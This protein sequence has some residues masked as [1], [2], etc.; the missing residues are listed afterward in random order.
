VSAEKPVLFEDATGEVAALIATLYETGQRLEELTRR[1]VDTVADHEGNTFVLQHAQQQLRHNEAAKKAAVLNALP[2]HIALLDANGLIVSVNQAWRQFAEANALHSPGHALGTNYLTVCDKAEG[3]DSAIAHQVA[4][5]V[6]SVLAQEARS[7]SIEYPCHSPTEQRWFLM[8]ATPMAGYR[9]SGAVVMHLN[10]T[11][12]RRS[13]DA[14]RA[15][16]QMQRELAAQLEVEHRRLM[17]AQRI[18]RIGSWEAD[19]ATSEVL[20]SDETHRIF[21]TDPATF[22]VTHERF[23]NLVHPEDRADVRDAFDKSLSRQTV[24]TIQHRLLLSNARIKYVEERW[25]CVFDAQG[26]ANRV[27]GTCQDITERTWAGEL[28]RESSAHGPWKQKKRVFIELGIL[29][30]GTALVYWLGARFDLSETIAHWLLQDQTQWDEAIVAALF[31]SLAL[32]VFA[33]SRLLESRASLR[34]L[35]RVKGALRLLHDDLDRQVEQRT[36]DLRS[37]NLSLSAEIAER[38][39]AETWLRESERRLSSMMSNV[40]LL[41]LMLDDQGRITYCNEYLLTLCGWS[42]QDVLGKSW[43]EWFLPPVIQPKMHEMFLDLLA[44]KPAAWHHEHEILTRAGLRRTI[45]WNNTLLRSAGG[46]VIGTASIG[47]DITQRVEQRRKIARLDR[48]RAVIGGISSAMLRLRDRDKLLEEACRVAATEGVFPMAWISVLD[49]QTR[50]F[51]IKTWHGADARSGDL[52]KKLNEFD[53]WPIRDRPS[54]RAF[55]AARPVVVNDLLIDPKMAPIREELLRGGY[56]SIAAFPLFVETSVVAV[57]MLLGS[58]RDFFD[59]EEIALLQWLT[60]DL[61]FAL[62]HIQKSQQLNYLAYYDPVT[63]LPNRQLFRDCLD[64]FINT[65]QQHHGKVCVEVVDLER[66]TQ[67]NNSLGRAIGDELLRQVGARFAEFLVEPYALGHIGA[68]TFAV[69][70]PQ[71]DEIAAAKLRDR[72]QEALNDPFMIENH[73]ISVSMQAGVALFPADGIDGATVFK[74]ADL[75]LKRAKSSGERYL[76]HSSEMN[77]R[78]VEQLALE[79]QLRTAI[80]T[81]QFI[82]HYQPKVDMIS[83]EMIGAEALIRW[84]HP[85][86]GLLNP[87]EFVTLAEETGL[88]VPIGSW[89]I[90]TVCAQQAT[91][92]KA[93]ISTVPIAVNLSSVQFQKGDLL[94]TIRDALAANAINGNLLDLELTE[95]VV[96]NDSASAAAILHALRKLGVGLALDDFGTGYSSLAHLKRFPFDSVKIDISF[97]ADIIRNSEDAAIATAIIAMAHSLQLKVVAEGVETLGQF[98]YLRTQGCDQMQGYFFSP[99]VT[100]EGFESDLRSGKRLKLPELPPAEQRTLLLVDDE[101]GVRAS[102]NRLLRREG[103]RILMAASGAEALEMLAINKVQVI[104]S[105][106]RMPGMS[107]TEFLDTVK[108]MYPSTIRMILS[109]YTDLQ[110]VTDSVNRGAVF[111]FLTKPWDDNLL[112]EL[113]RDAFRRYQSIDLLDLVVTPAS[114]EP[115]GIGGSDA[116]TL[117]H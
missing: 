20:W 14:L 93:G 110:V 106:Q 78:A 26:K 12:R 2:A 79:K 103:Y 59:A 95:S 114:D 54:Y 8:S 39:L 15:G 42:Q 48:I 81:R 24:C 108:Q 57:L 37:A 62:E 99:P 90:Q 18:A 40:E 29:A 52:I 21:E 51:D 111:K 49:P 117:R 65:A 63:G 87:A 71:S 76:Y 98:C 66:F 16:E 82:L 91:W 6:R 43:S 23:L 61:S 85:D 36:E 30:I 113:I 56:Q 97:V 22:A 55:L 1:E 67:I 89:V 75:A 34:S 104:V 10:I 107:G 4:K 46:A 3:A 58:E 105:D 53:A 116:G 94:Q 86:K 101:P 7:F 9:A 92:T 41:S 28:V 50:K 69:A 74:N 96:M 13:E 38:K 77:A 80:D 60:A 68:D 72:L 84:Q 19:L 33:F 83:G 100:K 11:E 32:L 64:Q 109:G 112:R 31:F 45:R 27:V 35:R 17:A 115:G 44:N 5:G 88:I 73:E 25:H 47:E 70:S 102:L